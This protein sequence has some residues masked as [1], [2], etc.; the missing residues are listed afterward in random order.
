L[1]VSVTFINKHNRC[2]FL[3]PW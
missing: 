2:C 1:K 3:C